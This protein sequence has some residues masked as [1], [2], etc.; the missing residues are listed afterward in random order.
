MDDLSP[1]QPAMNISPVSSGH[2]RP[3]TRNLPEQITPAVNVTKCHLPPFWRQDPMVWFA[4]VEAEFRSAHIIASSRKFNKVI[5]S[6]PPDVAMDVRDIIF[7]PPIVSPYEFVK[8]EIIKRTSQSEKKRLQQLLSNEVLG[9][10]S[11]SQLLR[12]LQQLLGGAAI[13]ES[14]LREIFLNRLPSEVQ[15]ILIASRNTSLQDLADMADQVLEITSPVTI[16]AIRDSYSGVKQDNYESRFSTLEST[17]KELA[18]HVSKL[19]QDVSRL[20]SM[21]QSFSKSNCNNKPRS[22]STSRHSRHSPNTD[23][24]KRLCWYHYTFADQ[25]KKC[26]PPCA[27]GN[28]SVQG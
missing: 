4:Q 19:S 13:D 25:A 23:P 16:S 20:T 3:T 7:N 21:D 22:R 2:E 1:V 27:W 9:D 18:V 12:K 10:Q 28:A 8:A 17:M 6:L 5:A 24:D 14:I 11:P 26:I 15:K